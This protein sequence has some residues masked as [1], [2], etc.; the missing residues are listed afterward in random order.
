MATRFVAPQSVFS[1]ADGNMFVSTGIT[2]GTVNFGGRL[3]FRPF[4]P[5]SFFATKMGI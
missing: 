4:V 2:A 5:P 1:N 3:F